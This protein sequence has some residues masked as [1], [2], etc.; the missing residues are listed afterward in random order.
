MI[1]NLLREQANAYFVKAGQFDQKGLDALAAQQR[2]IGEALLGTIMQVSALESAPPE[3]FLL[4]P[5]DAALFDTPAPSDL[6]AP[7]DTAVSSDTPIPQE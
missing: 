6:A 5:E 7:P 1:E 2:A 3:L 4:N